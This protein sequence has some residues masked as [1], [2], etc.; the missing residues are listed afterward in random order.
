MSY[1]DSKQLITLTQM[2]NV[3]RNNLPTTLGRFG[4]Y[5]TQLSVWKLYT[6]F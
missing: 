2:L 1:V 5:Y 3:Y 6:C 4:G